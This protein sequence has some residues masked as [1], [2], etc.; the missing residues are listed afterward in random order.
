MEKTWLDPVFTERK[1]LTIKYDYAETIYCVRFYFYIN[2]T[3]GIKIFLKNDFDSLQA[4]RNHCFYS[5]RIPHFHLRYQ[6]VTQ[7]AYNNR[8]DI[9]LIYD[10]SMSSLSVSLLHHAYNLVYYEIKCRPTSN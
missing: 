7:F 6:T 3:I 2:V 5:R 4:S 8:A 10:K 1:Q 9:F